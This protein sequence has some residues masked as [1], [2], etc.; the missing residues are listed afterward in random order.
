MAKIYR[1]VYIKLSQLVQENV[2]MITDLPTKR[3]KRY[4]GDKHFSE[5]FSYKMSAKSTGIDMAQN[6]VIITLCVPVGDVVIPAK[7]FARDYVITGVGLSVCLSV[8]LFV[9]TI[10]K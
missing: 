7:A 8:C 4:H 5:F 9:T 6:Y 2:H 3:F 10:I 1:V